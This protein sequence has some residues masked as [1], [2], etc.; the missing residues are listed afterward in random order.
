MSEA[1][2]Y[3]IVSKD[4]IKTSREALVDIILK[5]VVFKKDL[6]LVCILKGAAYF[7][8]DISRD[9]D[10][11]K[12]P[13]SVY[14]VEA[15]SY[16][17]QIQSESIQILSQLVPEKLEN[18]H[19]LL[20][21]ELYDNGKTLDSIKTHLLSQDLNSDI[22][23]CVMFKKKRTIPVKYPPP[24]YYGLAVPDVW[25]VGYGLDQDGHYRGLQDLYAIKKPQGI[26]WTSDDW[27]IF[28]NKE[29]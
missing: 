26:E 1:P 8:V 13:H 12:V 18:K 24:D 11:R 28:I 10:E 17:G 6:V 15:T 3:K 2:T 21:D 9:F 14:F 4:V 23:T 5:K 16:K 22:T 7:T 25:I 27:R 19:I 20:L 29:K